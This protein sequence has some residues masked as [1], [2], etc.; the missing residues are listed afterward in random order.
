MAAQLQELAPAVSL[1]LSGQN[2]FRL[3]TRDGRFLLDVSVFHPFQSNGKAG[4]RHANISEREKK[5]YERYPMHRD[6]QRVTDATLI[7]V[8]LNT[9]GAVGENAIEFLYAVARKEAKRVI[10]ENK[11]LAVLVDFNGVSE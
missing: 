11:M 1:P 9:Y 4:I 7:P 10:D 3:A 5:N 6:G 2:S 8:I